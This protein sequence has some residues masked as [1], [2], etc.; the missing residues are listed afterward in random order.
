MNT[1]ATEHPRAKSV[2][3]RD[4]ML[5]ALLEDGREIRVPMEWFPWLRDATEGQRANWRLI[6]RGAGIHW[7]DLDED[8]SVHGL[9]MP[10]TRRA[11]KSA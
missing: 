11:K 2:E 8:L 10:A 9:L 6:G 5:I 7:P 4:D 3:F 1:L